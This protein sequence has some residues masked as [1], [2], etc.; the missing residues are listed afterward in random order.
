MEEFKEPLTIKELSITPNPVA[1]KATITATQAYHNA[2]LLV[3]ST[4]GKETISYPW[5]EGETT[6]QLDIRRFLPGTYQLILLTNTNNKEVGKL[7]VGR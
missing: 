5:P 7:V 6:M 1:E 2:S 3:F 4:L